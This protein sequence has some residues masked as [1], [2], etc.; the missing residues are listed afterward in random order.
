MPHHPA[1]DLRQL[2][3]GVDHALGGARVLSVHHEREVE[4]GRSLRDGDDVDPG[5]RQGGEDP[6]GDP[7]RAGHPYPHDH[8]RRRARAELDPVDLLTGDLVPEGLE[9]AR[10]CPL[11]VLLGDAETDRVLRRGLADERDGDPLVVHRGERARRDPG[12]AQHPAPR[13][14]EERLLGDGRERLHGVGAE[15]AAARDLGAQGRGVGERPDAHG[16]ILAHHRDQRPRVEHPRAVVGELRGL[17]RVHL[18][19]HPRVGYDPRVRGEEPRDVLPERH[20][21]GAEHS[22]EEGRGEVRAATAERCHLPVGCRAEESRHD[23]DHTAGDERSERLA[24]APLGQRHVGGRV[25]EDAVGLHDVHG[26]HVGARAA[27][28]LER[29]GDEARAEPLAP[30][31]E[32]IGRARG[33]LAQ[34]REPGR[35]LFELRERPVDRPQRLIEPRAGG[36][37]VPRGL[38][39]LRPQRLDCA[40]RVLRFPVHGAGGDLEQRVGDARHGRYDHD[41]RRRALRLHDGHGVRDRRPIRERGAPELVDLQ[42][43]GR[44]GHERRS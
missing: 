41:E 4:L 40:V 32:I 42:G 33:Q 38:R 3:G 43:T 9:Q 28:R 11:R 10:P 16:D 8:E 21:P 7:R 6:R 5:V 30:G 44:A 14:G 36:E 34:D 15:G 22:G 2:E 29:R 23:R 35:E 12:D 17:T 18:G 37:Q 1:A 26:V 27:R 31:E 39:V 20:L 24:R 25:A 19:D 13:H